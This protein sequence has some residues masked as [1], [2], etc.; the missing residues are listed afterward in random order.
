MK[1][2]LT[3]WAFVLAA[4]PAAWGQWTQISACNNPARLEYAR[5]AHQEL[6]PKL[7]N[8]LGV[9][10]VGITNCSPQWINRVLQ[11]PHPTVA[12]PPQCG[13]ALRFTSERAKVAFARRFSSGK[14]MFQKDGVANAIAYCGEVGGTA[15]GE[16]RD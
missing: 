2:I 16:D 14:L 4:A 8:K 12:R 11:L 10:S 9:R 3:A 13:I 7:I 15:V 5:M 1:H 6:A